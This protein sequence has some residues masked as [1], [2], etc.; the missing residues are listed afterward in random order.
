VPGLLQIGRHA[1]AHHAEADES[2]AHVSLRR[3]Q[4]RYGTS[5][6]RDAAERKDNPS[7]APGERGLQIIPSHSY[8]SRN[9]L[10]GMA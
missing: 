8:E 3:S 10:A 5:L 2:D 4:N 9:P 7:P 6:L 1:L